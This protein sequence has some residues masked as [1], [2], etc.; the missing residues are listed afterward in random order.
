ML[1][2]ILVG[3][4]CLLFLYQ[5]IDSLHMHKNS[6]KH[7]LEELADIETKKGMGNINNW[8]ENQKKN[9]E[10][11][12]AFSLLKIQTSITHEN[13]NVQDLVNSVHD[14][15]VCITKNFSTQYSYT[16]VLKRVNSDGLDKDFDKLF[17]QLYTTCDCDDKLGRLLVKLLK[18]FWVEQTKNMCPDASADVSNC[19]NNISVANFSEGGMIDHLYSLLEKCV[20]TACPKLLNNLHM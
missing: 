10:Y 4:L 2:I 11:T 16:D 5:M 19:I 8:G 7:T 17:K 6:K 15:L 20:G 13:M 3:F 1:I 14:C 9:V 18:E 12:I